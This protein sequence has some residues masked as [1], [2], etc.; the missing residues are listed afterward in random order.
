MRRWIATPA[1]AAMVAA[2]L[3]SCTL[4]DTE[5]HSDA[6]RTT[7]ARYLAALGGSSDDRG[8]SILSGYTR[9]TYGERDAYVELAEV[10]DAPLAVHDIRLVYEDDGLYAFSVT[11]DDPIDLAYG[12]LLFRGRDR[13]AS[14]G[15][16]RSSGEFE[17]T[18]L[19]APFSDHDGVST[20]TCKEG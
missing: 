2:G 19:I 9:V 4:V 14:I 10:A 11:T 15:C 16:P 17:M 7:L 8:W 12:E 18:V 1:L 20:T 13:G 3:A 6:A 5:G